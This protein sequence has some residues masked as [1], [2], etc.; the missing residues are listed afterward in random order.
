MSIYAT[1]KL[2]LTLFYLILSMLYS[3]HDLNEDSRQ[4]Q[5]CQGRCVLP[6]VCLENRCVYVLD[7]ELDAEIIDAEVDA[8]ID[9]DISCNFEG[10]QRTCEGAIPNQLNTCEYLIQRCEDGEWSSCRT[11]TERCDGL[12]ND[13]DGKNDEDFNLNESCWLGLGE[14]AREGL[15]QCSEQGD[16][17]SC[18]AE[19]AAPSDERCDGLDNDCDGRADEGI[20]LLGDHCSV[21]L[22]ACTQ[23]GI[24][25][26]AEL[27]SD[28][29]ETRVICSATELEPNDE[30]CDGI[31]NDCDGLADES[32]LS[33]G[34]S[35]QSGELGICAQGLKSCSALG[36]IYCQAIEQAYDERCDGLDNDCD[37][38]IDEALVVLNTPCETNYYGACKAGTWGCDV[39][40]AWSCL[41]LTPPQ[42]EICD[43]QDNDCDGE[44]D[45]SDPELGLFCETGEFGECST[46][47]IYCIGGELLC[48]ALLS[49]EP[50]ICDGI[51]SDCD[52]FFDEDTVAI[53]TACETGQLGV[54][55]AGINAC[56][57]GEQV[58][59]REISPSVERCDGLDNDCDGKSDEDYPSLGDEC[60]YQEASCLLSGTI[61]CI[62]DRQVACTPNV[63]LSETELCDGRDN[64][65]DGQIDEMNLG[66]VLV[67]TL[68]NCGACGQE[69]VI[70]HAYSRCE[71]G[72][73]T[74][75]RCHS[76]WVDADQDPSNGCERSCAPSSDLNENCDGLDNDCDG[77][78]DEDVSCLGDQI[79]YCQNRVLVG[80]TDSACHTFEPGVGEM[81]FYTSAVLGD[82]S[83]QLLIRRAI[84]PARHH[85]AGGLERRL[86]RVG[87]A[88]EITANLTLNRE[89]IILGLY[90]VP[91]AHEIGEEAALELVTG[92][93]LALEPSPID[94][95][96]LMTLYRLED[97]VELWQGETIA[98]AE[99]QRASLRWAR[100]AL[101][102][103]TVT[104][105]G[106]RITPDFV[107]GLSDPSSSDS[108][109]TVLDLSTVLTHRLG[110]YLGTY[111][112]GPIN[113][114]P[115]SEVDALTYRYDVDGDGVF[116]PEDNCLEVYNPSQQDDNQNGIGTACDD[117]DHDGIENNEDNCPLIPNPYQIDDDQDGVG[118]TC[119]FKQSLLLK[120]VYDGVDEPWVFNPQTGRY[121][122]SP[123]PRLQGITHRASN[124]VEWAYIKDNVLY[125]IDQDTGDREGSIVDLA[126]NVTFSAEG[127]IYIDYS[128]SRV[129][130]VPKANFFTNEFPILLYE[131]L[132]GSQ[133]SFGRMGKGSSLFSLLERSSGNRIT[134]RTF[135]SLGDALSPALPIPGAFENKLPYVARHPT[136]SLYLIAAERGAA[137][138][139]SIIDQQSGQLRSLSREAVKAA[140]FVG[141]QK[142]FLSYRNTEEGGV[143]TF[144]PSYEQP[145]TNTSILVGPSK[146]L[147]SRY[148]QPVPHVDPTLDSDGDGL[149]DQLD[150]CPNQPRL[151]EIQSYYL[152]DLDKAKSL[153]NV[154]WNGEDLFINQSNQL[155]RYTLDGE[156]LAIQT[157]ASAIRFSTM[158]SEL[159]WVKN[160]YWL[161]H[162]E[163]A[164][165]FGN[166][167]PDPWTRWLSPNWVMSE[168]VMQEPRPF[169]LLDYTAPVRKNFIY[170]GFFDGEVITQVQSMGRDINFVF[171][172]TE[173]QLLAVKRHGNYFGYKPRVIRTNG[174][175]EFFTKHEY[176][177]GAMLFYH[178]ASGDI[179][180]SPFTLDYDYNQSILSNHPGKL[181]YLS[182][183]TEKFAVYQNRQDNVI[184]YPLII[185]GFQLDN[186]RPYILSSTVH[187]IQYLEAV[188]GRQLIGVIFSGSDDA[189]EGVFFTTF[190]PD[191]YQRGVIRRL[192]DFGVN[193]TQRVHLTWTGEEWIA[194]WTEAEDGYKMVKGQLQCP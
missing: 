191:T 100:D 186:Q 108:E 168:A 180:D 28:E 30:I 49:P 127:L 184:I 192:S 1:R 125:L 58:C 123:L 41:P 59:D 134:L 11:S 56:E 4:D 118:D 169:E 38:H 94:A 167:A 114:Y 21:G 131:N 150:Q 20:R 79:A 75:D 3:C 43:T 63:E 158:S 185:D 116:A 19:S 189:G 171:F 109:S 83:S 122:P 88:F 98:L 31:D 170:Q 164:T 193:V 32:D 68:R 34:E 117:Q 156:V 102:R 104:L 82:N 17:T 24:Y 126:T 36:E 176:G 119:T 93:G 112:A 87:P 194:I 14:C 81:E 29:Q 73:C 6:S 99:G 175:F 140:V 141:Q 182:K 130:F 40:E 159:V 151:K 70:P 111:Q 143:I 178:T 2:G 103:F 135:S 37:G 92:Y 124:G 26:C 86:P 65:C 89:P 139:L 152:D 161:P 67:S 129:F 162:L 107:A 53:G 27:E 153:S 142:S 16:G 166:Y 138:G 148:L 110:V 120:A 91:S 174:G 62:G 54:C 132:A 97:E 33:I 45:E 154:T 13:C 61:T 15:T 173:G 77:L 50:E 187:D 190:N 12:D 172:D 52:G 95:A 137:Q 64:D 51:D 47:T 113:Q 96:P 149:E 44:S 106:T 76:F 39:N 85:I 160:R 9:M 57:I 183:G 80:I 101:G 48:S 121:S 46:G 72:S 181:S 7:Q 18:S 22:G 105:N 8:L 163:Y 35:C 136:K 133:L 90:Q 55:S 147:K 78:V 66:Q 84:K 71:A 157:Y 145:W 42:T 25:V 165:D 179:A 74:L 144:H 188:R 128:G 146:T 10:E 23:T 155:Y 60:E 69:C 5:A 177:T 115:P